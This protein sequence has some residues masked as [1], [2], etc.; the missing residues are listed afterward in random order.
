MND[1]F[2]VQCSDG[3]GHRISK[4][5]SWKLLKQGDRDAFEAATKRGIPSYPKDEDATA[6]SQFLQKRKVA[7]YIKERQKYKKITL[8]T[9]QA[10]RFLHQAGG[11]HLRGLS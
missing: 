9:A 8:S 4:A 6:R 1:Y 10:K 3:E 11:V 2:A 5:C 7:C